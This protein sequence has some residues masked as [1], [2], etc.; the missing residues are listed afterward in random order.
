MEKDF[1][2]AALE[3][4][5]EYQRQWRKRNPDKVKANAMRDWVRKAEKAMSEE[6]NHQCDE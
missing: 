3:A 6:V 4:R 1:M 5:R 2:S